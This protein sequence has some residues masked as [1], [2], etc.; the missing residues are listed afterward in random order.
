VT[1][2]S[3]IIVL[4]GGVAGISAAVHLAEAGLPVVLL[5]QRKLLGGRAGSFTHAMGPRGMLD[6]SQHVLLGCCTALQDLYTKLGVSH[7]IRFDDTIRFVDAR[8]TAS[9]ME[10]AGLP[11]PLHLGP[12]LAGFR[13]LK[14]WQKAEIGRAMMR[15]MVEGLAGREAAGEISFAAYLRDAGQSPE[16][17]HDFWDVICVSALNEPCADACAKYGM[18]VFQEAF[19]G[20]RRAYRLGYARTPLAML[21]DRLPGVQVRAS[22]QARELMIEAGRVVGVRLTGGQEIRGRHVVLATGGPAALALIRPV[23][24]MDERLGSIGQIQYRP[25]VGAHLLYDRPVTIENP[26]TLVGTQLQWVFVDAER[27][28]L[29]HGVVSAADLLPEGAD[30]PALFDREL[31]RAFPQLVSHQLLEK[32]IVKEHRATFR[33]VPG[34]DRYR[35]SQATR[36]PGLTLAGDYT[37]TEW[38][39]TMEGAARSGMLAAR[40][41]G[42]GR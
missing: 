23:L 8:G 5:E 26:V 18:Q 39:A 11:S 41:A 37:R 38:P 22:S 12:S 31:K 14:L 27:P 16:T 20:D 40:V 6:S 36:I 35:P 15:M 33:P 9:N 30:L 10:A 19:L 3:P 29:V 32:V 28:E 2:D 13:L 17:I 1:N 7:L 21:Y 4:G 42:Q 24:P 34:I 25:I